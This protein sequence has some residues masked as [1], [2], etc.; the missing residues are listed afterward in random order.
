MFCPARDH[1]KVTLFRQSLGYEE[2]DI[3]CVYTGRF[4]ASKGPELLAEAIAWLQQ[5]GHTEFKGLFVGQ[6]DKT[7]EQLI[8]STP[9]CKIHP[10]VET[11]RLP[12]FYQACNIGVWPLQ[13]STSQLDAAACGL[14]IIINDAVEDTFRINGNGLQYE[15]RNPVDLAA[16]ML[17][18]RSPE[19][20]KEM[21]ANGSRKIA[22]RYSWNAIARERESDFALE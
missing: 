8:A 3:V 10:F 14:P 1:S 2:N 19:R 16:Q 9:G 15:D 7:C 21:G 22:E 11:D 17:S 6:G 4:T 5:N 18:L 20:R 13:E 12:M